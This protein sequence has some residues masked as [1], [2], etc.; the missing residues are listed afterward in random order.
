MECP[1]CGQDDLEHFS[2]PS[3]QE[4]G[5]CCPECDA[6]WVAD[7]LLPFPGHDRI[8]AY[9]EREGLDWDDVELGPSTEQVPVPDGL[10][11][12]RRVRPRA[13]RALVYVVG[14][15]GEPRTP[16][17][18]CPSGTLREAV[19]RPSGERFL[20]CVNCEAEWPTRDAVLKQPPT[21]LDSYLRSRGAEW[22]DVENAGGSAD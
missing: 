21:F 7:R 11:I 6:M 9:V 1:D 15:M 20:Y 19:L 2:I 17:A 4:I 12:H 13:E 5:V 8:G 3:R 16:C 22:G 14:D 10:N 18:Y